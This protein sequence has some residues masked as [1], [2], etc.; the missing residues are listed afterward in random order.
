MMNILDNNLAKEIIT[1]L[2]YL[3]DSFTDKIPNDLF[4]SLC[5][6]AADASIDVHIDLNKRL[7]EQDVSDECLDFIASLY[8]DMKL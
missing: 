3:D 4:N 5:D 6:L 8:Y 1:V 7:I 2:A